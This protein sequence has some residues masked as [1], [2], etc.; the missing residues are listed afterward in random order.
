M[1]KHKKEYTK[2]ITMLLED[3]Y[4]KL[5]LHLWLKCYRIFNGLHNKKITY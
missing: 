5:S 3:K 4:P 2:L 1:K